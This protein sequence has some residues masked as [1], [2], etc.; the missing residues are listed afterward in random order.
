MPSILRE[1]YPMFLQEEAGK[2]ASHGEP[3]EN[4]PLPNPLPQ[5]EG[6]IPL[7]APPDLVPMRRR[8]TMTTGT[9]EV[10]AALFV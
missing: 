1:C 7:R 10:G 3:V 5:E 2:G 4:V 9:A 8:R 6:R